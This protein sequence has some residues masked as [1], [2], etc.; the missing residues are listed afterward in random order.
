M[1]L[2]YLIFA[3]AVSAQAAAPLPLAFEEAI[4]IAEQR[5]AR[6]RA[7]YAAVAAATEQVPRASQLPDPKLRLG[8][9]NVPVSDPDA[10]SVTRD[11]MTMRRIGYMQDM[12]NAD[13]R[14]ARGAKAA[15]ERD[16]ELT[17]LA[18]QRAQVRQD[19]ALA[20]LEVYYAQQTESVLARLAESYKLEADTAGPAV[21]AGRV[22]PSAVV[23]ARASV[24]TVR[25]RMLEQRRNV[26]RARAMLAALVGEAGERP[27]GA[28]P[29]I[30]VLAHRPDVLVDVET[31]PAQRVFEQREALAESEVALAA[32]T[33]KSDWSW[34][35]SFGH[36]EPRYSNMVSVM[37]TMDL[38][39]SK[40][41][42]Q[43]RDVT[44][45]LK[46]LDQARALREDAR[47]M[48]QAEV[49]ALVAEW[50]IAGERSRGLEQKLLPL[51]RERA[52]LALAAYRG[53]RGE[54]AAVF[55]SRRAET[56]VSI[57][58][59]AAELERARAWARLNYLLHEAHP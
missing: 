5:S 36:R 38:P 49:R 43:D 42:R 2:T 20:W 12:P 51:T 7:G 50:Q 56:D 18:A 30:D 57:S 39:L 8:L 1:Q 32:S 4:E 31:H 21:S 10:F 6:L 16:V 44:V 22:A 41:E 25:D 19:I 11:F 14:Q 55:E 13:K 54:L 48:H 58:K 37:V 35:V 59:L 29:N 53:G 9:D 34:E 45:R 15:R 23:A 27:L 24:E 26:A 52:E 17:L 3:A 28:P 40:R 47:R 46:Q 33:R